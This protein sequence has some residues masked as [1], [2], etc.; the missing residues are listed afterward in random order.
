MD[1]GESFQL[2][3]EQPEQPKASREE[4]DGDSRVDVDVSIQ[5]VS[6]TEATASDSTPVAVY[7]AQLQ[8]QQAF[9]AK[10]RAWMRSSVETRRRQDALTQDKN[11]LDA[12]GA[13]YGF[14]VLDYTDLDTLQPLP[15]AR[16]RDRAPHLPEEPVLASSSGFDWA[17]NHPRAESIPLASFPYP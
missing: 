6:P 4:E 14:P 5:V 1:R 10:R 8:A 17:F 11:S 15:Q 12:E 3:S 2:R 7:G 13:L 9:A 16:Q